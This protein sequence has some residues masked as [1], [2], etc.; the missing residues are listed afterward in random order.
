MYNIYKSFTCITI[1][2][3]RKAFF[4]GQISKYRYL[5]QVHN[6]RYQKFNSILCKW[7]NLET[8]LAKML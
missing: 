6:I 8:I 5:V 3:I 1:R 7:T 2:R 4:K